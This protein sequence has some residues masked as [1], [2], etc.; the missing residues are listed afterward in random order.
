MTDTTDATDE[1]A[2]HSIGYALIFV[3]AVLWA[4][5]GVMTK[6]LGEL[7]IDAAEVG[8]WR[9][10]LG[11]VCFLVHVAVTRPRAADVGNNRVPLLAFALIGVTLFYTALPKAVEAGGITLAYVLMYTAPAWVA[12]GAVLVLHEKLHRPDVIAIAVTLF[13]ALLVS[14]S[15]GTAITVD[16]T[17]VSWGLAAGLSYASYYLLGRRLF[18]RLGGPLTY[19]ICLPLGALVLLALVRPAAP[20]AEAWPW[21]LALGFMS[22]YLPYLALAAGMTRV[23]SSRAVVVAT[24]EPVL[25]AILG[26]TLYDERLGPVGLLGA[27]LVLISAVTVS[28]R[29]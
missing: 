6:R 9:A 14:V 1:A 23:P 25:A 11:G 20:P 2:S 15:G 27:A 16:V 12:I 22:T 18:E 7:D 4:L 19:A 5:I 24:S 13:G 21:L 26:A 29:R 10:V 17:S 3:A 28:Q 8:T